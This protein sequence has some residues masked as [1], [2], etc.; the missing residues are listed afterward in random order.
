M[1]ISLPSTV[2]RDRLLSSIRSFG[3]PTSFDPSM[4]LRRDLMPSELE[5]ERVARDEARARNLESNYLRW[6]VR[7]C[8]LIEF[9]GPTYRPLP[10]NYR[11]PSDK[12]S[13]PRTIPKPNSSFDVPST[14]LPSNVS[15]AAPVPPVTVSPPS[16]SFI[17]TRDKSKKEEKKNPNASPL[18]LQVVVLRMRRRNGQFVPPLSTPFS[19]CAPSSYG[20]P[21]RQ[22]LSLYFANCRS[23]RNSIDTVTFLL[24]HRKFDIF[25]L[26]ET[27]LSDTDSEAFLLSGA[28]DYFVFRADRVDSRGGGVLIYAHSSTLP[29]YVS[30]LIIPGFECI[31]IDIFSNVKTNATNYAFVPLK[32]PKTN[33]GFPKYLG[34]LHDRLLQRFHNMAPNCDST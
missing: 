4:F 6:G 30:S 19:N 26:T 27:W 28:S 16:T 21:I 9:K 32:T 17:T 12:N 29:V 34:K 5:Q 23:V 13:R 15:S 3:R 22:N 20:T 24:N 18:S 8:E 2:L 7:H 10:P 14:S 11:T 1:K 25:A 31:A 33:S